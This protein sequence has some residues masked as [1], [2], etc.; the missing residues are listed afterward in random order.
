MSLHSDDTPLIISYCSANKRE[1]TKVEVREVRKHPNHTDILDYDVAV[2]ILAE[3]IVFSDKAGPIE[4]TDVEPATGANCTVS[5]W[6]RIKEDGGIPEHL[7]A[8]DVPIFDHKQCVDIYNKLYPDPIDIDHQV[9][10]DNMVCAGYPE[11]GKSVCNGDSGG[12]LVDLATGKLVGVVSWSNGCAERGYPAVY[13]SVFA[14]REWILQ[15][16]K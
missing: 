10:T 1:G 4:M 11:G 5:G 15:Q 16:L 13:A 2:L 3:D 7:L 12:P 14:L 6:G 9:V 8:V